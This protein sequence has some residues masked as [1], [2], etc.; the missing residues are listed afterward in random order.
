MK[1]EENESRSDG[2]EKILCKQSFTDSVVIDIKLC[3]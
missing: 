1:V 2:V 3:L